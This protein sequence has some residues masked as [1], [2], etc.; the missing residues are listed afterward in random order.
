MADGTIYEEA[1]RNVQV[2]ISEWVETPRALGQEMPTPK[3]RLAYA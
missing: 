3:G 1:L 2:I